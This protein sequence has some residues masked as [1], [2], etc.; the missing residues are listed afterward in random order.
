MFLWAILPSP[1]TSPH[2]E[3]NK[4]ISTFPLMLQT[5]LPRSIFPVI[6]ITSVVAPEKEPLNS[7][8]ETEPLKLEMEPETEPLNSEMEPETEPLN[9]E[10][11]PETEPLNLEME[12]EMDSTRLDKGTQS[13][14]FSSLQ[15]TTKYVK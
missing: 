5:T 11:E 10:M 6:V 9:S 2:P 7:E 14:K 12:P 15:I 8:P 1:H 3:T 4:N 13:G